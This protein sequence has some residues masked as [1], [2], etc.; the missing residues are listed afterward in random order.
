MSNEFVMVPRELLD[1]VLDPIT[2]DG[3]INAKHEICALMATPA[4]Q[5]QG[6]PVEMEGATFMG[7]PNFHHSIEWYRTGISKHWKK[8]CEQ[9]VN[10]DALEKKL[11]EALGLL[12]IYESF[13]GYLIDHCEGDT[14]YE[15]SLQYWLADHI[16]S[17]PAS[18]EPSAPVE[19]EPV[20]TTV[21][22]DPLYN[23]ESD[24]RNASSLLEEVLE[25]FDDG[26]G[27]SQAEFKLMRKIGAWL[28]RSVP[29]VD[30][31]SDECAHSYANK[32]GCPECGEEFGAEPNP[33]KCNYCGD[34][35]KIMV[36]R[37]GDA[38]DGN[39]PVLEP[40]EDCDRGAPVEID[41]RA[42]FESAMEDLV[43]PTFFEVWQARS[44]LERNPS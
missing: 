26:V 3:Y 7:E 32:V 13:P 21:F 28:G 34:T 1:R 18:A 12:R 40:C 31:G 22:N 38:S 30:G 2:S 41:E 15:E 9:R 43:C 42:A 5:H 17:L 14:I 8:I 6:E 23:A 4:E 27:R 25:W 20:E 19:V 44:A 16:K 36:G 39:A 35:G 10:I 29:S 24:A 11:A 33:P 37:S